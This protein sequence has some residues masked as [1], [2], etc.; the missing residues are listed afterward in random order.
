MAEVVAIV[1]S[2]I[3]VAQATDRVLSLLVPYVQQVKHA[4][5]EVDS[6]CAKVQ[7]LKTVVRAVEQAAL[8]SSSDFDQEIAKCISLLKT[9]EDKLHL[10]PISGTWRSVMKDD[11]LKW[12]FKS[13]EIKG[14]I[15][16]LE[17]RRSNLSLYL[18]VEMKYV[19]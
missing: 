15:D 8:G 19:S 18:Q 6:L 1:A 16:R 4:K 7:D 2:G 9:I 17:S 14:I 13:K 5:A 12:P 11:R 10:K 3:A